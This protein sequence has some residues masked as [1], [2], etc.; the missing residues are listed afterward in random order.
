MPFFSSRVAIAAGATVKILNMPPGVAVRCLSIKAEGATIM[1]SASAPG[2][3]KGMTFTD[4]S[5]ISL[6]YDDLKCL[7]GEEK[8]L[9]AYSA[10]GADVE[11]FGV[12][13]Y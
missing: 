9:Y 13:E 11:L 8:T 6:S 2:A 10:A 1:V 3:T 4:G 5:G 7:T 12:L